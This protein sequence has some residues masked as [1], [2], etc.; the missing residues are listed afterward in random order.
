MESER[1]WYSAGGDYTFSVVG[2]FEKLKNNEGGFFFDVSDYEAIIEFYLDNNEVLQASEAADIALSQH[3]GSIPIRSKMV[4]VCIDRG[5]APEALAI[6]RSLES[7]DPGDPEMT[8]MKGTALCMAGDTKRAMLLF[9]SLIS[10]D[11]S[12]EDED[13]LLRVVSVF[14]DLNF[15]KEAIIYIRMLIDID[16][17]D[18]YIYHDYAFAHDK[19]G[20]SERAIHYYNRFLEGDP[21]SDSAWYNLG[22]I[23]ARKGYYS[24]ALEAYEFALAVNPDNIFAL[25][26]KGNVLSNLELYERAAAVYMEYLESDPDNY[27]AT[28]Y[29]GECFEKRGLLDR[30]EQFFSEAVDLDPDLADGWFG[31]ALVSYRRENYGRAMASL[32]RAISIDSH[33]SEYRHL[34]AKSYFAIGMVKEGVRS[35][36]RLV[37]SDPFFDEAWVDLSLVIDE[38]GVAGRISTI[39]RGVA[40]IIGDVPG[41]NYIYSACLLAGGERPGALSALG[42]AI[43][44]DPSLFYRFSHMFN[45]EMLDENMRDLINGL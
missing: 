20:E 6:I 12:E 4:R 10:D 17:N 40:N 44:S 39:L 26:N 21:F 37:D 18:Y 23:Y 30:A 42:R 5:M 9:N 36:I 43:D 14:Q 11:M 22:V 8:F 25:Y 35:L 7:L 33:N 38:A 32:G 13:I 45:E 24:K 15:Y 19:I 28:I 31:L 1:Y 27:E 16:P 3:P 2:R 34:L 29:L 41:F